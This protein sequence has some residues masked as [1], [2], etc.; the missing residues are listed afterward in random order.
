MAN[1]ETPDLAFSSKEGYG[2]DSGLAVYVTQAI[3]AT[4]KWDDIAWLKRMTSLPVVVKGVLTG[5][6]SCRVWGL[7]DLSCHVCLCLKAVTSQDS[8]RLQMCHNIRDNQ[9]KI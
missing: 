5:E 1:F 9:T 4:V 3:D 2:E 6:L 7:E 8:D